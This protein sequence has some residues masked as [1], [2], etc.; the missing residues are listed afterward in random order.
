MRKILLLLAG[1]S[2]AVAVPTSAH[3]VMEYP[4]KSFGR[5]NSWLQWQT[6]GE[7]QGWQDTDYNLTCEQG[8]D[9]LWYLVPA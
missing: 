9:G 8:D 5:C 4:F 7:R 6:N 3:Y 1:S 2:I